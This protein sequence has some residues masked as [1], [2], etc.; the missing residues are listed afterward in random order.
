MIR[1]GQ[2][3]DIHLFEEGKPLMLGGVHLEGHP[4]FKAHSDGDV[5]LHALIDALLGALALGDI[6]QWF[7][8]TDPQY[9][10]ADSRKL[11]QLVL[12]APQF[13]KW[14]LVNLDATIITQTPKLAPSIPL[15]RES[16]AKLLDVAVDVIS[17]KAKTNE[18]L[19]AIG[20]GE[21]AAAS[22]SLLLETI[23]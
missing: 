10:N 3:N 20:R 7:P 8:D 4:G 16:L 2:G 23:P 9:A 15:I 19:D 14:R 17:V 13:A 18:H 11:L 5:L 21:A 12:Q 1:I 6:G 22:V